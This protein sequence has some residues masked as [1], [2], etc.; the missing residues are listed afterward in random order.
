[1]L[2]RKG[3]VIHCSSPFSRQKCKFLSN[4]NVMLYL[5]SNIHDNIHAS[6]LLNLLSLLP[7]SNQMRGILTFYR[8]SQTRLI[9]SINHEHSCKV[10]NKAPLKICCRRHFQVVQFLQQT[11]QGLMFLFNEMIHMKFKALFSQKPRKES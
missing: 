11:K 10:L 7:K 2:C 8:F 3:K 6:V 4:V 9:N 5:E 1:M